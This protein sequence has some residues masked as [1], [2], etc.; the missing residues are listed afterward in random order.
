[1]KT[2]KKRML[3]ALSAALLSTPVYAGEFT[4][5]LL[6]FADVDGNE[7]SALSSVDEF[8]ALV[9]AFRRDPVHGPNTLFVSSG[10]HIIQGP[11]FYAAEQRPVRALTG[12]N[13]PGHADIAFLN[14]MGVDAAADGSLVGNAERRLRLVTL[15]FLANGGDGYPFA[16]LSDPQRVNLYEGKGYG[17]ETD[18]PDANLSN[19]PGRNSRFSYTVGEQDAFA[20]YMQAFHATPQ[21]AYDVAETNAAQDQRLVALP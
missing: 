10:D 20:E 4:L 21:Q 9:D 2:F 18:Y 1:M 16:A 7:Q 3:T 8:S 12:S 19:D 15:N 11:R 6:H 17:E 14:A 13:E 5:Q